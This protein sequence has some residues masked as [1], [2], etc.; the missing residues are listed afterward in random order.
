MSSVY[1]P[2]VATNHDAGP[3]ERHERGV[4]IIDGDGGMVYL[5]DAFLPRIIALLAQHLAGEDVSITRQLPISDLSCSHDLDEALA[6]VNDQLTALVARRA[7][8]LAHQQHL[9]TTIPVIHDSQI[10]VV[11]L[12]TLLAPANQSGASLHNALLHHD[13]QDDSES[14]GNGERDHTG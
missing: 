1:V 3:R 6:D 12:S 5:P 9:E 13:E 8:I 11:S 14:R 10:E 2:I 7:A 4:D